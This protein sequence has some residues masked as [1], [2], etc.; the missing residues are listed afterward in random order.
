M[1]QTRTRARQPVQAFAAVV[2]AVFLVVGILGFIPGITSDYDQLTFGGHHSMAMLFGVFSVSVLHNL[3]H[4]VFGIAGLVLARGP[5]GARGY[6]VLGG[7]V[8]ILVCVYGI[9]IDIHS[10]MNFL[11]VNGADNWLHFGLGIGM[12]VL[13]I[14]GTAV[15]RTRES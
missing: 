13:G 9:V 6:L 15:Q 5:G 14:A 4:L 3:V 1:T 8:Y 7:F 12:I 10:G 2:G 11:P